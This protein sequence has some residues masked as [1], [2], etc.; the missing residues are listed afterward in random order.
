MKRLAPFYSINHELDFLMPSLKPVDLVLNIKRLNIYVYRSP[1]DAPVRTSFGTMVDRPAV[2][3]RIE[4][5]HGAYGWGEVW[6]NFPA[7]GAEYRARLLED[8]FSPLLIDINYR[9]P[10]DLFDQL[11]RSSHVLA[12]QTGEYGP[13]AQVIAGIDIAAWDL[14]AR[15]SQTP[16][17]RM[18]GGKDTELSLPVYASGISPDQLSETLDRCRRK[19]FQA[20]KLK[21]GFGDKKDLYNIDIAAQSLSDK[22]QLMVDANQAWD[23]KTAKKMARRLE[24]Y[25]LSWLEE[26]LAADRPEKEWVDLSGSTRLP[27]AIGENLRGTDGFV[28]AINSKCFGVIQPDLCKWGGF[29]GCLQVVQAI[30]AAGIRYCP[31]FLG[32]GIG[33]IASAHLLAA[34]GSNGMLEVDANNNPLREGLF[35]PFPELRNGRYYLNTDV[36]LGGEPDLKRVKPFLQRHREISTSN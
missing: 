33:L 11:S 30:I 2:L 31:H 35:Q 1:I 29:S 26:P 14:I 22:E 24:Q 12:I 32:G 23:L 3:I 34:S 25:P 21:I 19:G 18:L 27:L 15:R 8:Y 10:L 17:Y 16:I 9:S 36:G 6:C 13:I 5:G 28:E 20:F 7:C 4:D